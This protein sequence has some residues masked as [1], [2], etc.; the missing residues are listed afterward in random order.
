M[1][2]VID[3][4]KI[5]DIKNAVRKKE[6]KQYIG[7]KLPLQKSDSSEGYF[8]SSTTSIEAV[9]ENIRNLIL[10]RKGERVMNPTLGLN[11][12]EFLFEN[13]T[14]DVIYLIKEDLH[15]TFKFWLP[16]VGMTDVDINSDDNSNVINIKVNFY[17]RNNPSQIES[18]QVEI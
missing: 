9:K 12:D 14:E 17:M 3:K 4:E 10:T 8:E 6:K 11:L 5:K 13:I 1:A 18:V 15:T 7:L 16:F 2:I